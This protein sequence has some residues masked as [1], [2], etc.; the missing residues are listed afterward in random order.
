LA[1]DAG[2]VA[3]SAAGGALLGYG[4]AKAWDH[5][6]PDTLVLFGELLVEDLYI[7][8]FGLLDLHP[9]VGMSTHTEQVQPDDPNFISGPAGAGPEQYISTAASMP[10]Y[11]GFENEATADAPAQ[12]VK[13]TQQLDSD[14]DWSTFQLGGFGFGGQTYSIPAGR[15]NYHTVIDDRTSTGVY[16]DVLAQ[17]DPLTG[18]VT[19]T[20]TSLDPATDDIPEG[21]PEEGFLPPNVTEPEGEGWVTYFVSPKAADPTGTLISAQATVYFNAGLSDE[22]SLTTGAFVN[23]I[24]SG[25][26]ASTVAAL[27]A[28]SPASF[29][30]ELE[31]QRRWFRRRRVQ[32]LRFG[33][34]RRVLPLANGD[35]RH[36]GRLLRPGRPHVSLLQCRRRC[37]RQCR[38]A[39]GQLPS[40]HDCR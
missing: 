27:P 29:P 26:P 31:R 25:V 38:A 9:V 22:S 2:L 16:V 24:D 7:D 15:T 11:I 5:Y 8:S 19:W 23:T 34:Q 20:F 40:S 14:L 17:F 37:R 18:I 35:D 21:D 33:R 39:A 32:R 10:Y 1:G 36:P 12:V 30:G 3:L 4:I 13:V 28:A 6:S